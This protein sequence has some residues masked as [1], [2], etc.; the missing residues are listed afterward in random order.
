MGRA[1]AFAIALV[2]QPEGGA[3]QNCL[4]PELCAW[5]D[6]STLDLLVS[7]SYGDFDSVPNISD[8]ETKG[9]IL[10]CSQEVLAFVDWMFC[11][12]VPLQL[13]QCA[14]WNLLRDHRKPG[15]CFGVSRQK[16][17]MGRRHQ[18]LLYSRSIPW[19]ILE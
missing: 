16:L 10:A 12:L 6:P 2:L 15:Q 4:A 18:L 9:P 13:Y 17:R 7:N 3:L 5:N 1:C 14:V 19:R 8:E 11:N